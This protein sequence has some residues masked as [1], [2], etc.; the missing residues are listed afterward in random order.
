MPES[1]QFQ[2]DPKDE[3]IINLAAKAEAQYIVSRDKDL[4][5]LMSGYTD[6]CKEFRQRFKPLKVVEPLEFLRI[7][8]SKESSLRYRNWSIAS[9][10]APA[11]A[12]CGK[13][14]S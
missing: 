6:E 1:F 11:A 13:P 10:F 5:D 3:I 9:G 2:R 8:K 12:E 4:L 14:R 7:V